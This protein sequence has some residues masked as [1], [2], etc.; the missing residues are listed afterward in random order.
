VTAFKTLFSRY[1]WRIR[2]LLRALL[3]QGVTPRQLALAMAVGAA[4]GC[5]PLVWGTSLL[6]VSVAAVLRLN[7]VVVQAANYLVY[8]LQILLFLPYLKAGRWLFSGS[9]AGQ[10]QLGSLL[11]YLREAPL[12]FLHAFWLLNLQAL[13]VWLI[14]LP[15]L[16]AVAFL[17]ARA[18]LF[19]TRPQ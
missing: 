1:W 9:D 19:V 15:L 18:G 14:T 13:F 10:L 16:G 5:M 11:L 2:D 6:C 8:P 17:G 3:A 7:Q 12:Q 4:I